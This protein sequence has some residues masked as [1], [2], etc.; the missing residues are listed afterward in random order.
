MMEVDFKYNDGRTRLIKES[1]ARIL[2]KLNKGSYLTR[3]MAHQP[4]AVVVQKATEAVP[5]DHEPEPEAEESVSDDLDAME[6]QE[7]HALA[8]E[9][10]VDVHHNAGAPKVR[11]AIRAKRAEAA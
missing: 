11:E 2:Q 3:D 1:A 8:K 6:K 4:A 9:M 7:L 5:V 10:G